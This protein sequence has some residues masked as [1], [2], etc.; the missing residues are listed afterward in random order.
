M[1]YYVLLTFVMPSS[2]KD[3]IFIYDP[4]MFE[5]RMYMSKYYQI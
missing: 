3:C 1:F 2:C 4:R 5:A